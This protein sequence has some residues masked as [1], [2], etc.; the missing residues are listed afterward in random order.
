MDA[1]VDGR[2]LGGRQLGNDARVSAPCRLAD[3]AARGG[4]PDA[5]EEARRLASAKAAAQLAVSVCIPARDEQETVGSIASCIS[6]ALMTGAGGTAL[7]DELLVIDD[8]SVDATAKVAAEAGARVVS[9]PPDRRGKGEAMAFAL[10]KSEGDL[11]LFLDADVTSFGLHYVTRLVAPFLELERVALVKGYYQ[12]PLDGRANEGGRVTELVAKPAIELL[13]PQLA[14]IRQPLA[15]ESAAWR[16][17]LEK[18]GFASGYGVEMAL[19]IDVAEHFGVESI[20][21]VDLGVRVHRN[22][23]LSELRHQARE[24]MEVALQRAGRLPS[25]GTDGD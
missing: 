24:V 15:G 17:V 25:P 5:L 22:R 10:E 19:L 8:G 7:V 23:P 11:V 4:E 1:C 6:S 18:I 14:G 21:Q 3:P 16:F 13:F 2:W 9:T 12:R 20:A